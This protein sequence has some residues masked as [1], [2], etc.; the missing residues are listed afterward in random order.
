M[1]TVNYR[2]ALELE[3]GVSLLHHMSVLPDPDPTMFQ[4]SSTLR[5]YY[6][7]QAKKLFPSNPP[8]NDFEILTLGGDPYPDSDRSPDAVYKY[9]E[10]LY[11]STIEDSSDEAF[12]VASWAEIL[13]SP[14]LITGVRIP[15]ETT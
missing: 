1:P 14:A 10:E 13:D 12:M 3:L 9:L 7:K 11:K 15:C 4:S 6:L 5:Y 8:R 2:H